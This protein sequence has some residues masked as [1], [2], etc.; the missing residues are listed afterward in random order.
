M[1][2]L[3]LIIIL[4]IGWQV[5]ALR[6]DVSSLRNS[7]TVF[8]SIESEERDAAGIEEGRVNLRKNFYLPIAITPGMEFAGIA[9]V[10][11]VVFDDEGRSIY[12]KPGCAPIGSLEDTKKW[13]LS[14]G[15]ID[16][17]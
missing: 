17:I 10:I 11:R 2:T 5:I 3:I 16:D 9:L 8:Y 15:W 6:K 12:L 1:E 14:R 7:T 13:Y 4:V